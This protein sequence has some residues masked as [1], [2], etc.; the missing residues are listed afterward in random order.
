[1]RPI[2]LSA[3]VVAGIATAGLLSLPIASAFADDDPRAKRD[4]DTTEVNL[5]TADDDD[6]DPDDRSGLTA[7]NGGNGA[8]DDGATHDGDANGGATHDGATYRDV[9]NDDDDDAGA[10]SDGLSNS[11]G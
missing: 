10:S 11:N 5:V 7:S 2:T 4:E 6:Q 1:M 3:T 9:S 8:T